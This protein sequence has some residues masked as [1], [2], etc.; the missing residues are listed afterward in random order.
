M[1]GRRIRIGIPS[2]LVLLFFALAIVYIA[3]P[4]LSLFHQGRPE[5]ARRHRSTTRSCGTRSG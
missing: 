4:V 2:L 1:K 3:L 5:L